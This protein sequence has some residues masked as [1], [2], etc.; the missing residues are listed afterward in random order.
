M[1]AYNMGRSINYNSLEF[2]FK[3]GAFLKKSEAKREKKFVKKSF[4]RCYLFY[5]YKLF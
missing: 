1:F 2:F 3:H 4:F 5:L